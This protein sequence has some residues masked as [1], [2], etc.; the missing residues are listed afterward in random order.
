MCL[1]FETSEGYGDLRQMVENLTLNLSCRGGSPPAMLSCRVMCNCI[2][3]P[4]RDRMLKGGECTLHE[5]HSVEAVFPRQN[6]GNQ[7]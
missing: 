1:C 3:N 2:R 5:V 7:S 4:L 6:P